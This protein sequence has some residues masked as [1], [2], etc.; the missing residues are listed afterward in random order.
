ME[1]RFEI[2]RTLGFL[3]SLN[4]IPSDSH[5]VKVLLK[6]WDPTRVVFK[7]KDFELTPTIEEIGEFTNF[8]YQGRGMILPRKQ[9]GKKF[10]HLLGL[11]NNLKLACLDRDWIFLDYLYERFSHR[12]VHEVFS[13]EFSYFAESWRKKRPIIFAIALLGILVFPLEHGRI[14]TCLSSMV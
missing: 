14:E 8:K 5:I 7:F 3:T 9:L 11:R 4:Y 10:L 2:M 12:D 6:F 13:R 1:H